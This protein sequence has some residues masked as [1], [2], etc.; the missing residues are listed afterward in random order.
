[1]AVKK[2]TPIFFQALQNLANLP[3][4]PAGQCVINQLTHFSY[5]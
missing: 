5:A 3:P 1:M 4:L 2:K